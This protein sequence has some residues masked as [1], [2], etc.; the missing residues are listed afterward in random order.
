M[1]LVSQTSVAVVAAAAGHDSDL[2]LLKMQC[3]D[4]A[5]DPLTRVTQ[6]NV[7]INN[8]QLILAF[9]SKDFCYIWRN[10]EMLLL[11][12]YFVLF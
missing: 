4:V 7:H 6:R 11:Y 8:K 10:I 2:S 3:S 9:F 1:N 12:A 5:I